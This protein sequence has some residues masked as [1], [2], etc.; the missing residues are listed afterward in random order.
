MDT[1]TQIRKRLEDILNNIPQFTGKIFYDYIYTINENKLPFITITTGQETYEN[2]SL[3]K[4]FI[5]QKTL[6][7]IINIIGSVKSNYQDELD[8][9]K[10]LVEKAINTDNTLNGL[11]QSCY[12]ESISQES[13]DD[14]ELPLSFYTINLSIVYRVYSNNIDSIL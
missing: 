5:I 3:G 2:I 1:R 4:P 6:N 8:N 14:R 9:Y 11:V 10:N 12:I 13:D 7:A